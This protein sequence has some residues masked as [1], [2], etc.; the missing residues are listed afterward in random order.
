[1]EEIMYFH[2]KDM[3][4]FNHLKCIIKSDSKQL[5]RQQKESSESMCGT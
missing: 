4:F 1:M 5:K 3:F 2:T